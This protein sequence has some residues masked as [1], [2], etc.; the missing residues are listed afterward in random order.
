MLIAAL[1]SVWLFYSSPPR[2]KPVLA[3]EKGVNWTN[4]ADTV[5]CPAIFYD[6][7][8][9]IGI[10]Q[11]FFMN[12][13]LKS[14]SLCIVS[15]GMST[16]PLCCEGTKRTGILSV[17]D[18]WGVNDIRASDH[19]VE[20]QGGAKLSYV[21]TK[22]AES[23]LALEH[24]PSFTELSV[25][26]ALQTAS[27]GSFPSGSSLSSDVVSMDLVLSNSSQLTVS[28]SK[29]KDIF[30]AAIA[31]LGSVALVE[32]V[33]LRTVPLERLTRHDYSSAF[34]KVINTQSQLEALVH[35]N[36]HWLMLQFSPLCDSIIVRTASKS[37][38]SSPSSLL[39]QSHD[40]ISSTYSR[41][42]MRIVQPMLKLSASESSPLSTS[43]L[44][45]L[46]CIA[47]GFDHSFDAPQHTAILVPRS[48][49]AQTQAEYYVARENSAAAIRAVRDAL[50]LGHE[51][52][53]YNFN[54]FVTVSFVARE[55]E[56]FLAPN[57]RGDSVTIEITTFFQGVQ[58]SVLSDVEA[59]L[60]PFEPLPHLGLFNIISA[61]TIKKRYGDERIKSFSR[62][63][64]AADGVGKFANDWNRRYMV[65]V[66]PVKFI[67]SLIM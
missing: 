63:A 6:V 17:A 4:N 21:V 22:L 16:A 23:G 40:L 52:G 1:L 53:K 64:Y 56:P 65:N 51:Q 44:M 10:S 9:A 28:P 26:G 20:V 11:G 19:L 35:A 33:T 48:N 13:Y 18:L 32:S 2:P 66:T 25:V 45:N 15:T 5:T 43:Q 54:G 47:M 49:G 14:W 30:R 61:D 37:S 29:R 34:G 24:Q 12:A 42:I 60:E 38:S 31:G 36:A 27:H 57:Y 46:A 3:G 39:T 41:G 7:T 59:A 62:G 67:P 8:S 55:E 50:R 58:R